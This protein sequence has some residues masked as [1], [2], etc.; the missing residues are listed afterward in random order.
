MGVVFVPIISLP[1]H[2]V[3]NGDSEQQLRN[4]F[5][6]FFHGHIPCRT[7]HFTEFWQKQRN[8]G[9]Y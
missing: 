9:V 7:N 6:F 4:F 8:A 2:T 3:D 1:A 5:F